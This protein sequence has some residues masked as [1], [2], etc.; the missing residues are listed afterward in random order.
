MTCIGA[1]ND[2]CNED[3]INV[4]LKT[5]VVSIFVSRRIAK[6]PSIITITAS[7]DDRGWLLVDPHQA[8]IQYAH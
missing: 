5:V 8:D 1:A 6:T 7:I 2:N 3:A 4:A